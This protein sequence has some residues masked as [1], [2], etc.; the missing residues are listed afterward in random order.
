MVELRALGAID[1]RGQDG[2]ELAQVLTQPKRLGLLLYLD[3]ARPHGFHRRDRLLAMFW[4]ELDAARSRNALS[5]AIH[6]L[7]RSLG[8]DAIVTRGDEVM[9]DPAFVR[10]DV[11]MLEHAL[12]SGNHEHA[13]QLYRGP[14]ADGFFVDDSPEFERWLGDERERIRRAITNSVWALAEEAKKG[15]R[16]DESI[17]HARKAA[18]LNREDE[19]SLRRLMHFL[20]SVGDRTGALRAYDEF[21]EWLAEELDA[22]PAPD[23]EALYRTIRTTEIRHLEPSPAPP[24]SAGLPIAT[25]I[26]DGKRPI[27]WV[28]IATIASAVAAIAI[29][30]LGLSV[31]R[32]HDTG[33]LDP[34]RVTVQTFDNRTGDASHDA[35]G[36][37]AMDWISQEV[38]ASGLVAVVDSRTSSTI[39]SGLIVSGAY[40]RD[41]DR[42]RFQGQLSLASTGTISRVFAPVSV[43]VDAPTVAFDSIGH[44][45]TAAIAEA[46]DVRVSS[47]P[48]SGN[49]PPSYAA[50]REYIAGVEAFGVHDEE[51]A[52]EHFVRAYELDT[53]FTTALL[54]AAASIYGRW[55][56]A[57]PLLAMLIARRASL[58]PFNQLWLE[59]FLA[60]K[61]SDWN[62]VFRT[63]GELAQQA[64]G[65]QF[66][67]LHASS[68]ISVNRPRVALHELLRIDPAR[69]WMKNWFDYWL[70]RANARH[71]LGEYERELADARLG[72][73]Q[74]PANL[75]IIS[76]EVRALATVGRASAIDSSLDAAAGI[77][78][79][80]TWEMG[81]PYSIAAAEAAAHGYPAI[82]EKARNRTVEWVRSLPAEKLESEPRFFGPIWFLYN[83]QAWPEFRQ[84]VS[85]F[86][87]KYPDDFFWVIWE[88]LASAQRGDRRAAM[89]ADSVLEKTARPGGDPRFGQTLLPYSLYHRSRIAAMLGD[90]DRAV[91][92]LASAFANGYR[93]IIYVHSDPAFAS[94]RSD[95]RFVSLMTPR[96]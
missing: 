2:D 84:R 86:R 75:A 8:E 95:A 36:K 6:H 1:L 22:K 85:H 21:A 62:E 71:M 77:A 93:Y 79:H 59:S 94:I 66:P 27:P 19:P 17:S 80:D 7:R 70:V 10:S 43:P 9:L 82:A 12:A 41:G 44:Q 47:F 26:G 57:D 14:L 4:P 55:R 68:A 69:G 37:M 23:T 3:I 24:I 81:S 74:Y 63:T 53:T 96:D 18:S 65:S 38:A 88:G 91:S 50:Y 29:V 87:R 30:A 25:D 89:F 72:K 48:R 11:S 45:A 61:R 58:T 52:H 16:V 76:A 78:A 5:K 34:R 49:R 56:E 28:R 20:E 60:A 13:V 35:V 32:P 92:L 51:E 67:F 31:S 15:G 46:T 83:A 64:P 73:K 39:R 33:T 40:Y 54:N 42:L 90:R